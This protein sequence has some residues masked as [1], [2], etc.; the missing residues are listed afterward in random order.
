MPGRK[1]LNDAVL[2][3]TPVTLTDAATITTDAATGR[4]FRATLA[5]DRTLAAPTNP[6]DAQRA[7]WELT[8]S[9]AQ[10]TITL[11]TGSAGAFELTAGL[12]AANAIP[13]GKVAF[14][15]AIYSASRARWTALAFRVTS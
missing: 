4:H 8:A 2:P 3:I 6:T 7:L 15:A 13:S 9:G 1:A 5:G 14:L 10:R 12:S 11:T